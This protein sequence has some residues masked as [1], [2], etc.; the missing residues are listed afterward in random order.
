[1]AEKRSNGGEV[2]INVDSEE[3]PR[4]L[5]GS[6]PNEIEPL[7][8]LQNA[9][10]SPT[11]SAD[12]PSTVQIQKYKPRN[13]KKLNLVVLELFIFLLLSGCLIASLTV[14]KLQNTRVWDLKTWKWCVLVMVTFSGMSIA[15]WFV[16]LVVFLIETNFLARKKLLCFVQGLKKSVQVFIW[17]ASVLVTWLLLFLDVETRSKTTKKILDNVTW[18]L[19]S[20][21]IGTILWF[22][23]NSLFTMFASSFHK[24][25][26]FDRIQE[27]IFHQYLLRALSGPPLMEIDTVH[28]TVSNATKGKRAKTKRIGMRMEVDLVFSFLEG[29]NTRKI[30][31][32]DFA[33]WM[34][35]VY[36]D[37]K[38]LA[39]SLFDTRRVVEQLNKLVIAILIGIT[40]VIWL[41]LVGTATT[42]VLLVIA[43]FLFGESCKTIFQVVIFIF[44]IHPFD[45]GDCC[46]VD[47]VQV[48]ACSHYHMHF[49]L[50]KMGVVIIQTLKNTVRKIN[51]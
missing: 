4:G 16:G 44:V 42:R 1:M 40:F 32:K 10:I 15:R 46:V 38:A 11:M 34:V 23:K 50:E 31:R 27:S 19:V 47:D 17:L 48:K 8:P 13:K 18:V 29:S 39:C 37:R 43:A 28:S 3:N 22:L 30:N 35:K 6:A 49:L 14:D 24:N 33:N 21:L 2:V 7:D 5:K 25:K 26:F 51:K 12:E 45:V 36:M 41:L 9:Q 20:I